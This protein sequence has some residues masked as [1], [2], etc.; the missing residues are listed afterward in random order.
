MILAAAL[1]LAAGG[2]FMA[3]AASV[4]R[5]P[6][7]LADWRRR[8]GQGATLVLAAVVAI[9]LERAPS[10]VAGPGATAPAPA[11]AR[12]AAPVEVVEL[13]AQPVIVKTV[14]ARPA[15]LAD[16]LR[17]TILSLVLTAQQRGVAVVGPPFARYQSRGTAAEPVMVVDVGLP[18]ASRPTGTLGPDVRVAE[19]P[20]G[21]AAVVVHHGRHAE[22]GRAHATLDR[23][24]T[25]HHRQAAGPRWESYLTNPITTPDPDAQQTRVVVPLA[26]EPA[27]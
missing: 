14:R 13:V 1:F 12:P 15:A 26:A 20:A 17:D 25:A 24:L 9:G 4:R 11:S 8:R 21:A 3:A 5:A 6:V 27:R 10:A 19:L 18:V 2:A 22:L 16:T 23:W 7:E